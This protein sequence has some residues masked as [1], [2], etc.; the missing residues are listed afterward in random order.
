MFLYFLS[1]HV[2]LADDPAI[3]RGDIPSEFRSKK[4]QIN[5]SGGQLVLMQSLLEISVKE[6]R[7]KGQTAV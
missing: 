6:M 4:A 7:R 5:W 2:L 3:S 1:L